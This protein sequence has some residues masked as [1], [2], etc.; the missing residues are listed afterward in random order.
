LP[1]KHTL[2]VLF[3]PLKGKSSKNIS[4]ANNPH[5][6]QVLEAEKSWGLPR[7]HFRFQ[8]SAVSMTP[9][10]ATFE[11]IISANTMPYAKL[12]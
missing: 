5:T 7:P 6:V 1:I 3:L 4:M 10:L 2:Q 9:I 8:L 12:F 11:A